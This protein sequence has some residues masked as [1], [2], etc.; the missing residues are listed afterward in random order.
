MAKIAQII[1]NIPAQ[2][3]RTPFSYVLPEELGFITAGWRVL[4]PFGSRWQEGF[5]VD[6]VKGDP[7]GL[8]EVHAVLEDSPWFDDNML[9]L[10]KWISERYLCTLAAAMRLFLPGKT[11]VK[12]KTFYAVSP[13]LNG[14][15]VADLTQEQRKVLQYLAD[16]GPASADQ[17]R[18]EF[19]PTALT[20]IRKLVDRKLVTAGIQ[21]AKANVPKYQPYLRLLVPPEQVAAVMAEMA[22]KPAQKRLMAALQARPLLAM[23]DLAK[24]KISR[25]TVKRMEAAGLLEVIRQQVL[26]DSYADY[27]VGQPDLILSPE[28]R[29]AVN[30][31]SQCIGER[32]SASFVLHGITG[33]GKTQVYIEVVATARRLGRQAIVLVPEIALTSQ[34]VTRF[35]ARFGA[36]VV[37]MHSKLS[38]RERFDA[39]QRLREKAAGIVIGARS[40]LFAPLSDIGVIILDEEH[41]FTYKQEEIPRYHAREVAL[42][43]AALAQAAV[44]LGSATPAIETYYNALKGKHRL[45]TLP[46]RIDGGS[47]PEVTVVDMRAE[48]AQGRRGVISPPLKELLVETLQAGEQAIVLLNRRGY[49]TFVLCRECGHVMTCPHC[50]VSLVYYASNRMLRC[51]YCQRQQ[52]APDECPR[53]GSRYIRFFGTGTERVEQELAKLL[54]QAR[55]VRMD[56]DTTVGKLAHDRI[57]RDFA[58]GKYNILLGTQMVAKGHDI[59]NVTAVGIITADTALHLPDF[60]AAERTFALLTQAAGRAGRGKKPGRV[61]IQTYNPEHYAV[62]SG[63]EQD[64]LSFYHHEISFRQELFYPPFSDIIKFTVQGSAEQRAWQRAQEIVQAIEAALSAIPATQV[65]GPFPA[66]L[67]K[68]KDIYRMNILIKTGDSIAVRQRLAALDQLFNPDVLI[69]VDPIN[70]M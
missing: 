9:Q 58:A 34:L 44:V 37:V 22:H 21:A 15:D 18:R 7:T 64:Y 25:E 41:E 69:D 31:I 11:G 1:V 47:L 56:Q 23:S 60:R 12:I 29:Q 70:V 39:C 53:C 43:R 17:L 30:Y 46:A 14:T 28:Q 27:G 24:L 26:R 33:S 67:N 20:L 52:P 5:V 6:V 50:A 3:L 68:I 4:V 16:Q 54:P 8:K 38:I 48:L 49:A 45:L 2:T 61:V 10:A 55:I 62:Q 13:F 59:A 32:K 36:D 66:P 19:G 51:H 35:K 42:A 63:A 57:L 40:A 65:I